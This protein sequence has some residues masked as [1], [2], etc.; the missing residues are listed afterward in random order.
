[1][2]SCF[3]KSQPL[4]KEERQKQRLIES[5]LRKDKKK[6]EQEF[7]LLLLG[8][9]E[10]GKSTIAKQMKIIHLNG[11]NEEERKMY[12]DIIHSN[13]IMSVRVLVLACER[14]GI[15]LSAENKPRGQIFT[16]NSILAEQELTPSITEHV[17][18]LSCDPGIKQAISRS[19]EFQLNDSAVYYLENIDRI[20]APNYIPDEQ[21]VLRARAKT[22]GITETEFDVKQNHFRLVDVGGQRSERRK[23]IHCFQDVTAVIF[24]VAMSEYDQK[25]YEDETV[26]RM[27]ESLKLFDEICNSRWFESTSIILFLNKRDIFEEK[28]K[29]SNLTICFPEYAGGTD[30]QTASSFVKEKFSSLNKDTTAKHVYA[31]LTTATDT[32][33]VRFVFS[34]VQDMILH[35]AL[36]ASGF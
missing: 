7:K 30:F 20:A 2:G 17:K 25:L 32:S 26:N 15:E 12:K 21:D 35:E 14:L 16:A 33:N 10:S 27:H 29:K 3:V 22:T 8:A 5:Q 4:T 18:A 28:I 13:I 31:H 1:M 34:A 11:F 36:D 6:M 9:G 23:W 19:N 24:C